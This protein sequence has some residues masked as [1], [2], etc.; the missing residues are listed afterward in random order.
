MNPWISE[1]LIIAASP[2]IAYLI[3]FTYEAS[4]SGVFEIPFQFIT[5]NL[6]TVFVVASV[7]I[8]VV[9]LLCSTGNFVYTYVVPKS[10]DNP[11]YRSLV[12][13]FPLFFLLTVVIALFGP[14]WKEWIG[15]LVITA[16]YAFLEFAFP[17][18]T[19]KEEKT[20]KDKLK[21]QEMVE[22]QVD[23]LVDY[24]SLR[25]GRGGL[26]IIAWLALFAVISY[27]AGRAEALRK[28]K[29]LVI[30]TPPEAVVLRIYGDSLICAPFN[31][32]TRKVQKSFFVTKVPEDS[33]LIL[34]LEKVGPLQSI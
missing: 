20:Y 15:Y 25:V 2:I 27:S 14:N 21:S 16:F 32:E 33:K 3:T 30:P 22:A 12:R 9:L 18:I 29:F 7:L 26:K 23:T 31:R 28:D 6:T 19:Q 8:G 11:I 24:A 34:K 5:L 4:F 13:F 17:L 1:G 10:E